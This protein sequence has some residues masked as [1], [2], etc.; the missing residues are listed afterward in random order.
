MKVAYRDCRSEL[1]PAS[2][3]VLLGQTHVGAQ[4]TE[5][6]LGIAAVW[7]HLAPRVGLLGWAAH[8]CAALHFSE[9]SATRA[10]PQRAPPP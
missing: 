8:D 3:F 6:R 10:L 5:T 1:V 9:N 4:S 2:T 7:P